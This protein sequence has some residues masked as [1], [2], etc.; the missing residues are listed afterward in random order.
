MRLWIGW[1]SYLIDEKLFFKKQ[2]SK[3]SY[4]VSL[5]ALGGFDFPYG[6]FIS[7]PEISV[8]AFT[9]SF[10]FVNLIK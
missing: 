6:N 2:S 10:L 3:G 4:L 1:A 9:I 7:S 8:F 5:K